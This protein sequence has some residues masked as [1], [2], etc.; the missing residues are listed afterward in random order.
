MHSFFNTGN[1]V[2]DQLI[3]LRAITH[4]ALLRGTNLPMPIAHTVARAE[5]RLKQRAQPSGKSPQPEM[6]RHGASVRPHRSSVRSGQPR[7]LPQIALVQPSLLLVR[8]HRA[9]VTSH[10]PFVRAHAAVELRNATSV[11]PPRSS[12]RPHEASVRAHRWSGNR[13]NHQTGSISTFIVFSQH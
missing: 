11:R 1:H 7:L 10:A 2:L 6:P 8:A 3:G 12:V 13:I 4:E 5:K 9:F